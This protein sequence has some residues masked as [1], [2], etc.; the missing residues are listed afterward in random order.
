MCLRL[1]ERWWM[2]SEVA[3]STGSS[4]CEGP[5]RRMPQA[6]E[7]EP[8]LALLDAWQEL[9]PPTLQRQLLDTLVFPKVGG[10]ARSNCRRMLQLW[11]W[12]CVRGQ[13]ALGCAPM[14]CA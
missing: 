9:L 4:V 2:V 1:L 8:L 12:C 14:G 11:R 10:D 6:R 3:C 7:P 5:P 13:A